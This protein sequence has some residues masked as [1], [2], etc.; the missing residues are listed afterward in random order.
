METFRN[1][2]G[3]LLLPTGRLFAAAGIHPHALSIAGIVL[4]VA[5]GGAFVGGALWLGVV[6]FALSGLA[7]AVD[8]IVARHL[9]LQSAFGGFMDNFCSAYTDSAALSGLILANLCTPFWGLTAVLGTFA[10]LLTFRLD[11]LVTADEGFALKSRFPHALAGKGDRIVLVGLGVLLADVNTAV[12]VIAVSTN[13]IAAYRTFHLWR[14]TA[15]T[16]RAPQV[17]V[18]ARGALS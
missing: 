3:R 16:T 13:L 15:T 6:L 12:T 1:T 14:A 5:A 2:L 8:G 11:G 10:R 18:V 7:D 4:G 17:R 9:G